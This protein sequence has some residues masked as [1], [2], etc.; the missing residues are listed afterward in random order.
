MIK[1]GSTVVFSAFCFFTT[2]LN[3]HTLPGLFS[4][5]VSLQQKKD[6]VKVIQLLRIPLNKIEF[7]DSL[8]R[9]KTGIQL[10]SGTQFV[11]MRPAKNHPVTGSRSVTGKPPIFVYHLKSGESMNELSQVNTGKISG[12]IYLFELNPLTDGGDKPLRLFHK[13]QLT[14]DLSGS[15][16]EPDFNA[17]SGST[18]PTSGN[19]SSGTALEWK[20]IGPILAVTVYLCGWA[21]YATHAIDRHCSCERPRSGPVSANLVLSSIMTLG[22]NLIVELAL[23][24]F[25]RTSSQ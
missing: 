23:Y 16:L 14:E 20:V 17:T 10:L 13:R 19:E 7:I 9:N 2:C 18:S 5:L 4:N 21:I 6:A 12:N 3:A 25:A 22:S 8:D 11:V 15:G 24:Q 1:L